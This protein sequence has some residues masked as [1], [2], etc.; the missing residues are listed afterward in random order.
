MNQLQDFTASMYRY[1]INRLENNDF[2]C[3][4]ERNLIKQKIR[5]YK[6]MLTN[7][8]VC[9]LMAELGLHQSEAGYELPVSRYPSKALGMSMPGSPLF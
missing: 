1:F 9:I 5:E 3:R 7:M 2:K 6:Y 4:A 8:D